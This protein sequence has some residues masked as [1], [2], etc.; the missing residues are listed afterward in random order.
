MHALP[1]AQR[2]AALPPLTIA[3]VLQVPKLASGELHGFFW[4]SCRGAQFIVVGSEGLQCYDLTAAGAV[5]TKASKEMQGAANADKGDILWYRYQHHSRILLLGTQFDLIVLQITSQARTCARTHH[6]TPRARGNLVSMAHDGAMNYDGVQKWQNLVIAALTDAFVCSNW[7]FDC[8]EASRGS[9]LSACR[10]S[11]ATLR[12]RPPRR[13]KPR[14]PSRA[15]SRASSTAA[16]ACT[17]A[18]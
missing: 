14:S 18:S 9:R 8:S 2:G 17:C 15:H 4:T 7:L 13:C 10:S 11:L 6:D 5:S 16:C 12:A 3:L 1:A